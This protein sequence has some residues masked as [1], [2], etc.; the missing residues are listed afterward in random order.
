MYKHSKARLKI[1]HK[2]SESFDILCG[3]EQ[4]HLVSPEL[5]KM[6]IHKLSMELNEIAQ[7]LENPVKVPELN[8]TPISHILWADDIVLLARDKKSLQRL[9]ENLE[10]YCEIW[11]LEVS[12]SN[13]S[14]SKTAIMIFN[15]SGRQLKESYQFERGATTIPSTKS[16]TYL[17]IV[18][19]LSGS[20][21]RTQQILR[22]KG[23][24]KYINTKN[25][26]KSATFKLFDSLIV[27]VAT[28]GSQIW[29]PTTKI[30]KTIFERNYT[31]T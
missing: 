21:Q 6:Y 28:Y 25:V 8:G 12:I 26:P 27:P 19:T 1:I 17:G 31:H 16:Y 18:F 4:G 9:I 20:Q 13:D 3:T 23:M 5:F 30:C 22:Q 14:T 11:G 29:L 24:K 10:S 15:K 7:N 2:L